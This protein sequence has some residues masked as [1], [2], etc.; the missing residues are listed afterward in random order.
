MTRIYDLAAWDRLRTA[1]LTDQPL[2]EAC[3][4][5]EVIEIADTVDHIIAIE[6]GGDPFPP[7]DQLMSLC[8][9]CHNSKTNAVDHPN[10]SGFR[11]ALKGFDVEG[12]PIDP[13]GWNAPTAPS[14]LPAAD[15]GR[16]NVARQPA[17]DTRIDLVS[18][19]TNLESSKWV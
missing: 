9:A 17:G 7:L 2:C 19:E 10:A 16:E 1:K 11:R 6:K 12:N 13:E 3:L 14:A 15:S 5:R 8:E 18:Y 4:R